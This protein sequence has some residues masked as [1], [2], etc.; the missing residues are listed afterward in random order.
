ML[1]FDPAA[2]TRQIEH[3][4]A[5]RDLYLGDGGDGG[6]ASLTAFNLP[7]ARAAAAFERVDAIARARRA[8]GDLRTLAQLR[9][10]T[11]LDLLDGTGTD[12]PPMFRQGVL[13]LQ[14][15]LATAIGA[16]CAPADLAGYGPVLADV[17]RQ[18]ARDRND[19]QWRFSVTYKGELVY[20]GITKTRP[21]PEHTASAGPR[22]DR[23]ADIA[24]THDTGGRS[25]RG[26]GTCANSN[27]GDI[28]TSHGD[29][30]ASGASNS[31]PDTNVDGS[32]RATSRHDGGPDNH[33]T[34]DCDHTAGE[35]NSAADIGDGGV[36]DGDDGFVRQTDIAQTSSPAALLDYLTGEPITAINTH[37]PC[38]PVETNPRTRFPGRKL[39]T[40][41]TAR[42]RTCQAPGCHAPARTCQYDHTTD[43]TNGGCTCHD[44]L[45]LLC[46]RHHREHANMASPNG[47]RILIWDIRHGHITVNCGQPPRGHIYRQ[48]RT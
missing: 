24:G 48:L 26:R 38:P 41:I 20:Q 45:A 23:G 46:E 2:R 14:I 7:V 34:A 15:P 31:D 13:E 32:S 35:P 25:R 30:D 33:N 36:G 12:T 39:R 22:A 11:V 6:T 37:V 16:D 21:D 3:T 43:Y 9:A 4:T 44:N 27:A 28:R 18:I 19:L 17:A 10:D 40:W 42:D 8:G 47:D 29:N 5:D 1:R